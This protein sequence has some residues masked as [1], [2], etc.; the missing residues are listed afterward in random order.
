M[1]HVKTRRRVSGT[2]LPPESSLALRHLLRR[3]QAEGE[4]FGLGWLR[5]VERVL[6]L[7]LG[8]PAC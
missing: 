2:F 4:A 5:S 7:H 1:W 6:P 3:P 8:C